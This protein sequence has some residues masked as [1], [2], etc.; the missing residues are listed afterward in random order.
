MGDA[1][2][3]KDDKQDDN[4]VLRRGER[5]TPFSPVGRLEPGRLF[6]EGEEPML[7]SLSLPKLVE[8]PLI[9]RF[10]WV[11]APRQAS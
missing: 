3:N 9:E 2:N 7:F 8:P 1:M 4:P 6:N 5:I 10:W 11:L